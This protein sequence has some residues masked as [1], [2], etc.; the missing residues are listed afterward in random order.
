MKDAPGLTEPTLDEIRRARI[1]IGGHVLRT[2]LR[3]YPVRSELLDA[4][5]W[6]KH[7]NFQ[8]LGS[9]KVRGG[10]NLVSQTT[11]DERNR[12]FVTASSGNH[13]Q[14]I[15]YAA[16]AFGAACSV[17][18]PEGANPAKAGAIAALGAKVIF[19]GDV[20]DESYRHAAELAEKDGMRM[21]RVTDPA[22]VAGVATYSVE[23]H[24][25][26]ADIDFMFVPVG[27]GSGACGACIVADSVSPS[28]RVI[29]VQA[30]RAP[31][32][33]H[34]WQTGRFETYPMSTIAEGL[35][36]ED[37]YDFTI[38]ILRERLKEF[39]LVDDSDINSAIKHYV[40]ATRTLVEHAGA[41]PLA[42]AIN[43]KDRI[44][45]KRVVLVASGG[46]I[47]TEQLKAALS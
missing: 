20:F 37:A 40:H 44:Q 10:I 24:E 27:A 33:F 35:A 21:V 1:A 30:A 7:E 11:E 42:A 38:G 26:L 12:G 25:D 32:A 39:V 36:T 3:Q 28:T 22:L 46:N 4:D 18:L 6:V 47:T 5:V 2:P 29:A 14:S 34:A 19:H 31:A 23:V 16:R 9:F 15:A 41:A 13:G 8:L 45:G 17:V 43:M